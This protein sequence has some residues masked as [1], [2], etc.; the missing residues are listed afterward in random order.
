MR[1]KVRD[2]M[3]TS[4]LDGKSPST[5]PLKDRLSSAIRRSFRKKNKTPV[6]VF[7]E[8]EDDF[9]FSHSPTSTPELRKRSN[10]VSS[11]VLY[12]HDQS[13]S[14]STS[15]STGT[16]SEIFSQSPATAVRHPSIQVQG[17]TGST[18]SANTA[19]ANGS[20]VG[21]RTRESEASA[22]DALEDTASGGAVRL[23]EKND[24]RSVSCSL[25]MYACTRL[26]N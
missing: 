9:T 16:P 23:R 14:D 7:Q 12:P 24:K 22:G 3:S 6:L 17:A 20:V 13:D 18:A 1:V 5:P 2:V 26:I 8:C 11:S 15:T 10:T 25:C 21:G 19:S 4:L